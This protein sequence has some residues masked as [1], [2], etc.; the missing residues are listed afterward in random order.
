MVVYGMK[1]VLRQEGP[2]DDADML[3]PLAVPPKA[4]FCDNAN[5][6][7]KHVNKWRPQVFFQPNAERVCENTRKNIASAFTHPNEPD[8]SVYYPHIL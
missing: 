3:L 1:C 6:F 5:L 2:R 7:S 8:I 4:F